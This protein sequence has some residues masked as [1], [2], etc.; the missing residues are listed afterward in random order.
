MCTYPRI[1]IDKF[2]V[3]DKENTVQMSLNPNFYTSYELQATVPGACNL[4]IS[5][6]D[7]DMLVND[8]IGTTHI[9]VE[10]RYVQ[11]YE[12]AKLAK[13]RTWSV[14]VHAYVNEPD[15]IHVHA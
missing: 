12:Y 5:L 14:Y 3:E 2:V 15:D 8:Q 9:D 1:A 11:A 13:T 10:N 4:E 6:Y 7:A